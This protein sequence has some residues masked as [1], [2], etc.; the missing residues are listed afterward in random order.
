MALKASHILLVSLCLISSFTFAQ[1]KPKPHAFNAFYLEAL[2]AG[3]YGSVNY[4]RLLF[5]QKKLHIGVRLGVGTYPLRD[6]KTN[7][8]PDIMVPFGINAYYGTTHH[9]ELGIG[10][11]FS[12]VVKAR[13]SDFSLTRENNLNSYFNIGYRY[14]KG[15]RGMVFRLNYCPIISS[16]KPFKNWFALS[17]GYS[18]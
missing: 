9:V 15:E 2:G 10:Q 18:F 3:G 7:F 8:N 6:F 16:N 4:E 12:S 17:I 5:Q 13:S 14:Q 11:T 1:I